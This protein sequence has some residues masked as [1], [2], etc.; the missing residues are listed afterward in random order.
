MSK[1]LFLKNSKKNRINGLLISLIT[2]VLGIY[3]MNKWSIFPKHVD[4]VY[5]ILFIIYIVAGVFGLVGSKR[6]KKNIIDGEY[7]CYSNNQGAYASSLN[8]ILG[9]LS[10]G[11]YAII[12][13]MEIVVFDTAVAITLFSSVCIVFSMRGVFMNNT[14]YLVKDGEK[15]TIVSTKG[16]NTIDINNI[17]FF[18]HSLSVGGYKAVDSLGNTLFKWGLYWENGSRLGDDLEKQGVKFVLRNNK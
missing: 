13:L 5:L 15:I 12:F 11:M 17:K 9:I 1:E 18:T 6:G 8:Y 10:F 14:Y 2:V 16:N 4:F 7:Y 3:G